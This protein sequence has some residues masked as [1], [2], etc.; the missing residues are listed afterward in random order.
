MTPFSKV[1]S[2]DAFRGQLDMYCG[3]FDAL[4]NEYVMKASASELENH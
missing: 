2:F 4:E 1:T 3:E